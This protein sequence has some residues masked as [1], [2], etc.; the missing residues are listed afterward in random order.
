L[1]STSEA[2]LGAVL[3]AAFVIDGELAVL[4]HDSPSDTM[5]VRYQVWSWKKTAQGGFQL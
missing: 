4:S 5:V 3:I 2:W 1:V